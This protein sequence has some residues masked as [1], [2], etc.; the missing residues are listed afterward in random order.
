MEPTCSRC[1]GTLTSGDTFC[2]SC[3]SAV[4]AS[5]P[6][7]P[8]PES[9]PWSDPSLTLKTNTMA[10]AAFVVSLV[11]CAPIGIIMGHVARRQIRETG[12]QGA[13]FALAAII[14]GWVG[15]VAVIGS[16][17]A[18]ALLGSYLSTSP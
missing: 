9:G 12:E 15:V 17:V 2:G 11:A 18:L 10:I 14:I 6:S 5:T 4:A 1:G 8:G 13:G 3:G 16:V 7:S